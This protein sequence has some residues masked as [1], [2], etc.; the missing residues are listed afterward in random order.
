VDVVILQAFANCT[1]M[2]T[3]FKHGVGRVGARDHVTSGTP[4]TTF[5]VSTPLYNANTTL[6]RDKD[7]VA[8]EAL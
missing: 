3:L 2:H 6:D 8:C 1:A 5:F 7:G 4:V